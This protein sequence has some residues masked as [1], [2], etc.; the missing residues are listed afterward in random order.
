MDRRFSYRPGALLVLGGLAALATIRPDSPPE[1]RAA[2]PAE[3]SGT[4]VLAGGLSDP[5]VIALSV[6]TA[7]ATPEVDFLIDS[8]KAD[9]TVA[10]LL[11]DRLR[12]DR[13]DARPASGAFP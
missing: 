13:G 9:I 2:P 10:L 7:A 11:I 12:P 4:V 6:M 1:V 3:R 8:P 5:E